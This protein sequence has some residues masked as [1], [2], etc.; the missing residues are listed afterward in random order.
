MQSA[1]SK[2]IEGGGGAGSFERTGSAD[3]SFD[4]MVRQVEDYMVTLETS[5]ALN[6][7]LQARIS[8]YEAVLNTIAQGVG[9]FDREE[10]LVLCNRRYAEI[11]RLTPDEVQPG[12]TIAEIVDCR[13]AAGTVAMTDDGYLSEF[14][15]TIKTVGSKSWVAELLDGRSIQISY[16]TMPDGG[17]VVTHEDITELKTTRSVANERLSLQA[18]IDRLPDNLWVKDVNSRFII[19]NQVTA[20]RMGFTSSADL[21]GK[22]DL[23]LLAPEIA[24]KF[25]ADEQDIIRTGQPMLDMEEC[26]YGTSGEKSWILTTK[27]PLRNERSQIFGVAGISRDITERRLANAL[28]DG[29]ARILEMIATSAPIGEVLEQ[30]A[31]LVEFQ[32]SGIFCVIM[33]LGKDGT[34][35]ERGAAPSLSDT[36]A[37]SSDGIQ[38]GPKAASCGTALFRKETT[39]VTDI[40]VDPLWVD[41][42]HLAAGHGFRSCWSTPIFSRNRMPLG[43]F[44]M[45]SRTVRAP[46][47]EE[48]FL[49]DVA[50]HLASIAI[51][52]Q[53]TVDLLSPLR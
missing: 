38:V 1:K 18:L 45:Y 50:A 17:T 40:A 30:I 41:H 26:V 16:G 32:L 46:T 47:E 42:Q 37:A 33:L 31:L 27:V 22:S 15:S 21:I 52:R 19:A 43:T 9:V 4:A 39:I 28:S 35:L 48:S 12:T 6:A 8:R 2:S 23:E 11:Y 25:Y 29:Q 24:T 5:K 34:R 51:D 10:R 36:F 20:A 7:A 3:A 44:A 53:M 13:V 14:R 49:A